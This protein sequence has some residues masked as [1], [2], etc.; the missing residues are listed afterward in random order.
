MR[1]FR[2]I[3]WV[4]ASLLAGAGASL[5]VAWACSL[6]SSVVETRQAG[7]GMPPQTDVVPP[8]WYAPR[9]PASGE[10][11]RYSLSERRGFGLRIVMVSAHEPVWGIDDFSFERVYY[12]RRA[13]WPAPA[14]ECSAT[15][16]SSNAVEVF[17]GVPVPGWRGQ[18]EPPWLYGMP[19]QLPTGLLRGF[20]VDTLVYAAVL[21]AL[22]FSVRLVVRRVRRMRGRCVACGYSRAGLGVEVACPECGVLRR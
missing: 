21:W 2:V 14:L 12:V 10:T 16:D 1:R 8:A 13:G 4:I 11:V 22:F 15:R 17:H 18:V 7:G 19:P 6:R 9:L 20:A 5:G 3:L